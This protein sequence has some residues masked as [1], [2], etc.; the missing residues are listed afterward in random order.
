MSKIKNWMGKTMTYGGYLKLCGIMMMVTIV[1]T[2]VYLLYL[3]N[4]NVFGN[5]LKR[6][7][8]LIKRIRK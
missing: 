1:Y 6:I 8:E 3:F 4:P 7:K 5:T 2:V